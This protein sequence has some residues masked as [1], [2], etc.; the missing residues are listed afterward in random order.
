MKSITEVLQGRVFRIMSVVSQI[1][2]D[3]IGEDFIRRNTQRNFAA[4]FSRFLSRVLT[5]K[6]EK[7]KGFPG[8]LSFSSDCVVFT[9]AEFRSF[10][11][12]LWGKDWEKVMTRFPDELD[13]LT[14]TKEVE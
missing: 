2:L 11:D 12:C 5:I 3:N 4:Q 10:M 9:T 7:A 1:E 14:K 8:G 13:I 6:E